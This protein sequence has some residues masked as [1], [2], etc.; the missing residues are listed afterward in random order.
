MKRVLGFFRQVHATAG[1]AGTLLLLSVVLAAAAS[2]ARAM[3][4][5]APAVTERLIPGTAFTVAVELPEQG[6]VEA[7]LPGIDLQR[8]PLRFDAATGR[9]VGELV[10]PW[11]APSR[12]RATLRIVGAGLT[13]DRPFLLGSVDAT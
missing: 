13:I 12:G 11:Y 4:Q 8:V 9:Y 7:Y 10:L 2:L 6:L 1:P 3:P 5:A